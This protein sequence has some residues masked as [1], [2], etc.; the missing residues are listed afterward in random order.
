MRSDNGCVRR[1]IGGQDVNEKHGPPCFGGGGSECGDDARCGEVDGDGDTF[2]GC[3]KVD[4]LFGLGVET[5]AK[6]DHD[7][8]G[9]CWRRRR[10][11]VGRQAWWRVR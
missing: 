2:G 11:V 1:G 9:Q 7:L 10:R 5:F 8:S 4:S 6:L 3:G